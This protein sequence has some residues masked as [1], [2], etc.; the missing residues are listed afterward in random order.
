MIGSIVKFRHNATQQ[1]A[2]WCIEHHLLGKV[3]NEELGR[4][5]IDVGL[6]YNIYVDIDQIQIISEDGEFE[7]LSSDLLNSAPI[8]DSEY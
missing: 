6:P 3:I 2:K 7:P 4:L 5:Q 8:P 1:A